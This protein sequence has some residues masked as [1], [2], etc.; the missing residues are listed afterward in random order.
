MHTASTQSTP[1]PIIAVANGQDDVVCRLIPYKNS[2]A[3][4]A[5]YLGIFGLIPVVGLM[6]AMPAFILGLLGWKAYRRNPLIRGRVHAWIG[7]VLGGTSIAYH[8]LILVW[9]MI[10][11]QPR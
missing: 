11:R 3:L 10:T 4:T 7:L 9:V 2:P 1:P 5:Y 6:M 8:L